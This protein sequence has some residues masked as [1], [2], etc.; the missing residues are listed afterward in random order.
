MSSTDA[1]CGAAAAGMVHAFWCCCCSCC[2]CRLP[3]SSRTCHMGT[4]DLSQ[5]AGHQ[6]ATDATAVQ[7]GSEG[8]RQR[9]AIEPTTRADQVPSCHPNNMRPGQ[10]AVAP[11]TSRRP[12]PPQP[13]CIRFTLCPVTTFVHVP[14][15]ARTLLLRRAPPAPAHPAG[16]RRPG[17]CASLCCHLET[18]VGGG[19]SRKRAKRECARDQRCHPLWTHEHTACPTSG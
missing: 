5:Q 3:S 15:A 16:R 7:G 2:C 6:Q 14:H 12:L 1:E 11:S 17:P 8:R 10:P 13:I 19:A 18:H 9:S 4:T